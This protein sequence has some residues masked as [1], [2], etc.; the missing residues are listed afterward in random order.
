LKRKNE[1][2]GGLEEDPGG[3]IQKKK[4]LPCPQLQVKK[5]GDKRGNTAVNKERWLEFRGTA[6]KE[7]GRGEEKSN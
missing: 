7:K 1:C 6:G 4:A 5:K 3:R 2:R